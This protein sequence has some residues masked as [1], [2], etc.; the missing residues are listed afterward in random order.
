VQGLQN[1]AGGAG[2][3]QFQLGSTNNEQWVRVEKPDGTEG[4]IPQSKLQE[5][6]AMGAKVK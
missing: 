1:N 6:L 3:S 5:A 2:Q 4:E